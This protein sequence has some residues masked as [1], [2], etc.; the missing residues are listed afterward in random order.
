MLSAEDLPDLRNG[1][2]VLMRQI[3]AGFGISGIYLSGLAFV[4]I[5]A[6]LLVQKFN[7]WKS[8]AVKGSYLALMLVESLVYGIIL[9]ALLA[10]ARLLLML[11]DGS[12]LVQQLVLA[13]GAGF[14]EE[15]VFRALL[16]TGLATVMKLIFQW[17]VY[18]SYIAAVLVAALIFSAFHFLGSYG[19][20]FSW[21]LLILRGLAGTMLGVIF[22]TRGFGIAAFSHTVYDLLALTL[23]TIKV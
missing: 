12:A 11:S 17:H 6:I 20:I 9:F 5:A 8:Q 21:P 4:A 19:D 14:H 7:S 3:L 1:A 10:Q 22:V 15:F 18:T 13:I 2:D 23:V 16:I